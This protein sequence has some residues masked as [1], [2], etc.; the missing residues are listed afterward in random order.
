[1]RSLLE[2]CE[3]NQNRGCDTIVPI[4]NTVIW[5][6]GHYNAWNLLTKF[7][8]GPYWNATSYEQSEC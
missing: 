1:M 3:V 7:V 6:R 4:V 8:S 2:F 5:R